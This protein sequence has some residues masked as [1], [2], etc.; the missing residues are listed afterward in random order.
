MDDATRNLEEWKARYESYR[1]YR[2]QYLTTCGFVA[3]T[4][5][6]GAAYGLAKGTP[7]PS[8][9]VVFVFLCVTLAAFL[10]GHAIARR[11]VQTLGQRLQAL[12]EALGMAPFQSTWLLEKALIVSGVGAVT[13]SLCALAAM[14]WTICSG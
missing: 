9:L 12:E 4:I 10:V 2:A 3:T 8:R 11:A 5:G 6:L 13:V 1:Q 14:I 7:T